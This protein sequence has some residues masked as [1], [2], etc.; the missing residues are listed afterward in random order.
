MNAIEHEIQHDAM[1]L[2]EHIKRLV[3]VYAPPNGGGG[4][5]GTFLELNDTPSTLSLI[6]I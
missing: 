6:H 1:N 3:R 5:A 4:G 2:D